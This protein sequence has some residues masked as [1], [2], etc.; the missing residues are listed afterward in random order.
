MI[1][2]GLTGSTTAMA[3][4]DGRPPHTRGGVQAEA[5][6][7]GGLRKQAMAMVETHQISTQ[8]MSFKAPV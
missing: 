8:T 2:D 4:G 5:L 3:V 1:E 7:C 6:D